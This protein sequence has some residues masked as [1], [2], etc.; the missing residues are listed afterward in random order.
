MFL[1]LHWQEFSS[2][3]SSNN[4]CTFP[5]S[6]ICADI[7]LNP[8][9]CYCPDK[10]KFIH[11]S[12]D[13][14]ALSVSCHGLTHRFLSPF[15]PLSGSY[16]WLWVSQQFLL[17]FC[18][19]V[20]QIN[21]FHGFFFFFFQYRQIMQKME[22]LSLFL[23]LLDLLILQHMQSW[24]WICRLK[25]EWDAAEWRLAFRHFRKCSLNIL[26]TQSVLSQQ[27]HH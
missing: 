18:I 6:S 1:E 14:P 19:T 16:P 22:V 12:P 26:S 25:V 9:K 24:H 27:H 23:T 20:N 4:S 17:C 21:C 7:L 15:L 8:L 11:C 5:W 3:H 2:C 10:V 13:M